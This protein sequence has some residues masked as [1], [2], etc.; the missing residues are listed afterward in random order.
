[1]TFPSTSQFDELLDAYKDS[2]SKGFDQFLQALPRQDLPNVT[3]TFHPSYYS[4]SPCFM[5][6]EEL[7]C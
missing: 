1:M 2:N 7:E 5:A 4:Q 6:P 3:K